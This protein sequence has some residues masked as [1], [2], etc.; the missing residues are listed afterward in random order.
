MS[1][2]FHFLVAC[3]CALPIQAEAL[4]LVAEDDP[5][6][7][8]LADGKLVGVVTEK[9][10]AAL[11]RSKVDYHM[12][13]MPW[14]RAFDYAKA[15]EGYCV[16]STARTAERE[17]LFKW[18]GPVAAM[19]WVLY[20]RSDVRPLPVRLEEVRGAPI[21]GYRGDVISNWLAD[22]GY[23]MD[24]AAADALNP[25]KL[26][27]RRFDYWASSRP[28]ATSYLAREEG[29]AQIIP[30]LTFGHTDLYLACH[31]KTPDATIAQ[32]N[33]ALLKM[34]ADGSAA[35]I[36]AKYAHWRPN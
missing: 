30:V 15:R 33:A 26:L 13:I 36:E 35:A 3:L 4:E 6:H 7:N 22:K 9:L 23:T 24:L 5:P 10:Q 18:V 1:P 27:L 25:K 2:A 11:L 34:Q 31:A 29:A 19:D 28:R 32:L 16:F 21:G 12:E 14:A 17:L 8:M 20:A